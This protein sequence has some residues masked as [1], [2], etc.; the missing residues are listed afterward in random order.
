MW[1]VV[2]MKW[3]RSNVIRVAHVA[4]FA[5]AIQFVLSFGHFHGVANQSVSVAQSGPA[6]LHLEIAD[7]FAGQAADRL[8]VPQP[9]S[10]HSS[11]EQDD[12]CAVCAVM[13]MANAILF[14]TPPVALLPH[15]AG[16]SYLHARVKFVRIAS[17]RGAFQP[18]APP[19]S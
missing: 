14:A 15:S 19:I 11:G 7:N 5:L 17:V 2:N 1:G 3:F 9:V 16:F 6:R 12:I 8:S 18:R 4:L 10:D 13:A